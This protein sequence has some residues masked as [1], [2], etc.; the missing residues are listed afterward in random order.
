[1]HSTIYNNYKNADFGT[2]GEIIGQSYNLRA[3]FIYG[4]IKGQTREVY[5]S[6][7]FAGF[8]GLR[9]KSRV[10]QV[11]FEPRLPRRVLE[12]AVHYSLLI[13]CS[14]ECALSTDNR[15]HSTT[16]SM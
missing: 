16:K 1:M 4:K 12:A 10:F 8:S 3:C 11:A 2:E 14:T 5:D 13:S 7:I 9:M 6:S 15:H